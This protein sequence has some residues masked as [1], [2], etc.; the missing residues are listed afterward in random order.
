LDPTLSPPIIGKPVH[1]CAEIISFSGADKNSKIHVYVNGTK[2]KEQ[3]TWW[4]SGVIRLPNP[5]TIGNIVSTAQ[6]VST[7]VSAETREPVSVT[8]IPLSLRPGGKLF[9]PEIDPPLYECQK[10][11][12]VKNALES[13]TVTLRNNAGGT[14]K[15][16]TPFRSLLVGTPELEYGR[17]YDAMQGICDELLS[18]WSKK[19]TVQKKPSSLPEARIPEPLVEGND[20]CIV[21]DLIRGATVDIFA[22]D[23]LGRVRVG[24]GVT[25]GGSAV[26]KINPPFDLKYEYYAIQSLCE[27]RSNVPEKGTPVVKDVPQPIVQGP[28]CHGDFYVVICNTVAGSTVKVYVDKVQAGQAAGNGECVRMALGNATTF[29]KGNKVTAQQFVAGKPSPISASILVQVDG[30][31]AYNPAYWNDSGHIRKNNCYN[32]GCDIRNDKY[33]QPGWAHGMHGPT[34]CFSVGNRA[35][36]DG[37]KPATEKECLGCT[38]LVALAI[39]P[40]PPN[41]DVDYHWYRLDKNGRWSHKPGDTPATDLDFS[42]NPITNPETADRRCDYGADYIFDYSI[43]CGYYCVDKKIVVIDGPDP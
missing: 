40:K 20:A 18:D 19:E 30:A 7:G 22:D 29:S 39:A 32:Y 15:G 9:P 34:T 8:N 17:V 6:E 21:Y 36:A 38:H 42:K 31:P 43:F 12:L 2:V 11:V 23:G 37:L 5:L 16:M 10:V 3:N 25:G 26:F 35:E 33:A 41:P 24:G 13:A 1:P 28:I 14:W 27:T 4:G